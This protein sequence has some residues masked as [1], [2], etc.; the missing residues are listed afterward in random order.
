MREVETILASDNAEQEIGARYFSTR[1][2]CSPQPSLIPAN[3]S[4]EHRRPCAVSESGAS[5]LPC[6]YHLFLAT[7]SVY[8]LVRV[9]LGKQTCRGVLRLDWDRLR[10]TTRAS[11]APRGIHATCI[12]SNTACC[13]MYAVFRLPPRLLVYRP[14]YSF[15]GGDEYKAPTCSTTTTI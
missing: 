9:L 15:P 10:F 4:C 3:G 14:V 11:T 12:S 5:C 8:W 7:S 1:L 2:V 6:G 13:I